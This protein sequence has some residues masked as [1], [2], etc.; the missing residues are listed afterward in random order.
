MGRLIDQLDHL[1]GAGLD[2]GAR[3][4][5]HADRLKQLAHEGARLTAQHL[6]ALSPARRRA[7]LLVTVLDTMERLTDDAIGVFDR[8]VGRLFRRAERRASSEL[9]Q[10][11]WTINEKLRLLAQLGDALFDAKATGTDAFSAVANVIPWESLAVAI[12]DTKAL[13][14]PDGPDYL[15]LAEHNH[16]L[17]RRIGPGFL[18]AFVFQGVAAVSSLLQ[19]ISMLRPFYAG[20]RRSLPKDLP[21]G[22][23]RRSWR[24]AVIRNGVIDG[25]AYK[26]CLFAELRDRLRAGDVWV[27]GS[28]QYRAVED[29]LLAKPLFAAMKQAGSL[30]VAVPLDCAVYL[31]Q[32]RDLLDERLRSIADK[33]QRDQ[34]E[35]VRVRGSSLKITPLKAVTPEAA[36]ALADR[37]YALL[38]RVRIT[39]L[40]GE[41]ARWT[42]FGDDFT[43]L[44]SG[45]PFDDDRVI[46]TAVLADATNLGLTGMAEA[47]AVA[48][49]KQL[50]WAAGWHLREDTYGRALARI[51]EAQHARCRPRGVHR[52]R[53]PAQGQRARGQRLHP[54][55]RPLRALQQQAD[56]RRRRRGAA[57]PGWAA[58]SRR[59]PRVRRPSH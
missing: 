9:Q 54:H 10:N 25:A 34:L 52:S 53:Q 58:L 16:A 27:T 46:L 21:T 42:G 11:A 4:A 59:R 38:P 43:H 13:I 35:D 14:R 50:V 7:V 6:R 18:D 3:A 41:V 20:S 40:L 15:A 55:L 26:L 44:R 33:A 19:A 5:V 37:L 30:P 2:P 29:Q 31:Q 39:D 17:L 24:S 28:R 51:V 23:I 57:C 49:Y 36:E 48:T 32:R 56:L 12:K 47:C 45:L 8:L 1:R 22:F